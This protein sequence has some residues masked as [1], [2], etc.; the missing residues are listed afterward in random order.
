M[1]DRNHDGTTHWADGPD[2]AGCWRH[3][4]GCAIGEVERLRAE[5]AEA[6]AEVAAYRGL[7]EGGLPG[8]TWDGGWIR[9]RLTANDGSTAVLTATRPT[10][11]RA[12]R[13]GIE[14]GR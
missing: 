8:W 2:N 6:R 11:W 13:R 5:I 12:G 7:P 1:S 9:V 10:E 3:H 4:H 14:V